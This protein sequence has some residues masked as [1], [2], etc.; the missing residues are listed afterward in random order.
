MYGKG[1]YATLKRPVIIL[2]HMEM[3]TAPRFCNWQHLCQSEMEIKQRVMK[4]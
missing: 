3:G 1:E 2:Q 4:P